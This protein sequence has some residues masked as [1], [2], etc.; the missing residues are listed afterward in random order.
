MSGPSRDQVLKLLTRCQPDWRK[1]KETVDKFRLSRRS[2]NFIPTQ[3]MCRKFGEEQ[4]ESSWERQDELAPVCGRGQGAIE[5][6]DLDGRIFFH[7]GEMQG[8][9]CGC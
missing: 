4:I 5:I 7:Q 2:P 1:R 3:G 6:E 8:M 9:R